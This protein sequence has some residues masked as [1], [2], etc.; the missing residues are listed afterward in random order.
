SHEVSC[1]G[2]GTGTLTG[3]IHGRTDTK[4]GAVTTGWRPSCALRIDRRR[5]KL[6]PRPMGN[7]RPPPG[8]KLLIASVGVATVSYV[9]LSTSCGSS[10]TTGNPPPPSD[11]ADEFPV[12]NLVAPPFD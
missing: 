12:A 2:T 11:A 5:G 4:A 3:K 7:P 10:S 9:A 1:T 8:R 6:D